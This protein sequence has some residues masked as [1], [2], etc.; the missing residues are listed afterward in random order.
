[1]I[2]GVPLPK[3]SPWGEQMWF[4]FFD[5]NLSSQTEFHFQMHV[6]TG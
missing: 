3:K 1:M 5:C 2:S 4:L 6:L